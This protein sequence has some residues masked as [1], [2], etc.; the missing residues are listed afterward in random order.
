M[1]IIQKKILLLV[2]AI[3]AFVCGLVFVHVNDWFECEEVS[4]FGITFYNDGFVYDIGVIL[5]CIAFII[6]FLMSFKP[7]KVV[8]ETKEM[9]DR[10]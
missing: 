7:I 10:S 2:I 1:K 9:K 5:L 6:L 4:F 3:L 8:E